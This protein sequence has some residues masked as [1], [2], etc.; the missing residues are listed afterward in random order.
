MFDKL[1]KVVRL[2]ICTFIKTFLMIETTAFPSLDFN[3][4]ALLQQDFQ[5]EDATFYN[6]VSPH[7]G[8]FYFLS[9]TLIA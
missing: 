4:S 3:H 8:A 9:P 6:E 7:P 2:F 1:L 5:P